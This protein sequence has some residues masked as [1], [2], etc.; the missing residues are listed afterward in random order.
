VYADFTDLK[1]FDYEFSKLIRS[2]HRRAMPDNK[3]DLDVPFYK[4]PT[5]DSLI[6][7]STTAKRIGD[8]D[9]GAVI[10]ERG[11]DYYGFRNTRQSTL[12]GWLIMA[13]GVLIMIMGFVLRIRTGK[14]RHLFGLLIPGFIFYVAGS[15]LKLSMSLRRRAYDY[16]KKLLL[17]DEEEKI[18]DIPFGSFWRK[19][20]QLGGYN[21]LYRFSIIIEAIAFMLFLID[22]LI[23]VVM[24]RITVWQC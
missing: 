6:Q 15:T 17:I 24:M 21:K 9:V 12:L 4:K 14:M 10:H 7:D 11:S 19:R 23:F 13:S 1:K 18:F 8:V 20:L 2:I 22:I 3:I 5:S 16:D